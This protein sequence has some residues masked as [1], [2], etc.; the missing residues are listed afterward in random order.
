M[1][2]SLRNGAR[3]F[4]TAGS[5]FILAQLLAASSFA[6]AKGSD[7]NDEPYNDEVNHERQ[8]CYPIDLRTGVA[9]PLPEPYMEYVV[10]PEDSDGDG[11][12]ETV[13][14]VTVDD[15]H[16]QFSPMAARFIIT[17]DGDPTGM[18]VNIGDSSTNDGHSGDAATQSNDA[19]VQIGDAGGIVP[20]YD[21]FFVYG[22]DG[23]GDARGSTLLVEVPNIV[24]AG[25]TVV[26]TVSN[27][28]VRYE[29]AEVPAHGVIRS[30]WLY[31]LDGQPDTEGPVNY[32]IYAAFNRVVAGSYRLGSGVAE[33][34]VC[35]IGLPETV[36]EDAP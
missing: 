24:R 11:W 23:I 27:E 3:V 32:D 6:Y 28:Q 19:E 20:A 1:N 4:T 12:Y 34:T 9:T 36:L 14:R 18:S 22:R 7:Y 31:A 16:L 2:K 5:T 15:P 10:P 35:L 17:Y 8:H 29:N 21:N 25:E 13:V 33:V 30:P 26:L